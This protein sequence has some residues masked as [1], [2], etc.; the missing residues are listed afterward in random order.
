MIKVVILIC[1]L[2]TPLNDCTE[3]NSVAMILADTNDDGVSCSALGNVLLTRVGTNLSI[4]YQ[5]KIRCVKNGKEY[6]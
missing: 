2:A 4:G 5:A 1:Q 3:D 6:K